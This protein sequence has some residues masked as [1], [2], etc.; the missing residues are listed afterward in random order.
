MTT[1]TREQLIARADHMLCVGKAFLAEHPEYDG[2]AKD[3]EL[4][5]IALAAMQQESVDFEAWW[6]GPRW[7]EPLVERALKDTAREAWNAA[8]LQGKAEPVSNRDEFNPPVIP[9]GWVKCS[10]RMPDR[11]EDVLVATEFFA[12][13]DWR[14]KVGHVRN[15]TG[16]WH[17]YGAS[18]TPTYWMPLPAAPQQ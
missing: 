6:N 12:P 18:W 11:S 7:P 2:M 9:D 15:D 8:M 3:V 14:R 13:G 4:F 1:F 10:E 16:E 5:G 17:V